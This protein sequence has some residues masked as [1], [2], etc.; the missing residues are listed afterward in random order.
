M[1]TPRNGNGGRRVAGGA[2]TRWPAV[3]ATGTWH[4]ARRKVPR[5]GGQ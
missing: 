3:P 5:V 2:V 4:P 1:T